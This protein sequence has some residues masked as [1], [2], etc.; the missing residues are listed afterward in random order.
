M[1]A[2]HTKDPGALAGATGAWKSDLLGSW[3]GSDDTEALVL[4]QGRLLSTRFGL[5]DLRAKAVAHLA[6][7]EVPR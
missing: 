3:I 5:T 7:P 6:F 4:A 1:M 2:A